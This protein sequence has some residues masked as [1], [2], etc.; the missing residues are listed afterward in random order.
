MPHYVTCTSVV[1]NWVGYVDNDDQADNFRTTKGKMNSKT[2]R[3]LLFSVMILLGTVLIANFWE[4]LGLRDNF[5][6]LA[7]LTIIA[8]GINLVGLVVGF[9]ELKKLR[10]LSFWFGFVGHFII[11]IVLVLTYIYAFYGL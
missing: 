7:L 11:I 3:L 2:F 5:L 1:A 9:G 10:T 8:F 4:P 6:P